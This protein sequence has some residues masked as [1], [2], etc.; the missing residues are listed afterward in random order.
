MW[1]QEWSVPPQDSDELLV[2][3]VYTRCW[4]DAGLKAPGL[5]IIGWMKSTDEMSYEKTQ[6]MSDAI[7]WYINECRE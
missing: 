2:W 3:R 7:Y 6:L 4:Q 5:W 1:K